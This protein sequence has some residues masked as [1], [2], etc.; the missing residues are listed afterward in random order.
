MAALELNWELKAHDG[1]LVL[2]V[3]LKVD[4]SLDGRIHTE[5]WQRDHYATPLAH[6]H[7]AVDSVVAA[8]V[9][10]AVQFEGDVDW[11]DLCLDRDVC[12]R[13]WFG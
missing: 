10:W 11:A 6:L 3:E 4:H 8:G 12:L 13:E 2:V 7:G 5:Y 1:F 9:H